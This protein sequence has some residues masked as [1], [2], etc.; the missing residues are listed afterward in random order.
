[1][2][3]HARM[4]ATGSAAAR[5]RRDRGGRTGDA[6]GDEALPQ[7]G[8]F[9]QPEHRPPLDAMTTPAPTVCDSITGMLP[10]SGFEKEVCARNGSR[11]FAVNETGIIVTK[12]H[13]ARMR[14]GFCRGHARAGLTSQGKAVG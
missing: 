11:G 14:F 8:A 6:I 4:P 10:C 9:I 3:L 5:G 2:A 7:G 1:M 12:R 13:V